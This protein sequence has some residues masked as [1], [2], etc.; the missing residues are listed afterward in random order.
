MQELRL[1]AADFAVGGDGREKGREKG[2]E[3]EKKGTQ[4]NFKQ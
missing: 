4:L 3:A 1:S 2:D